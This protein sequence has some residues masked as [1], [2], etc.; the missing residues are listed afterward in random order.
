MQAIMESLFDVL[1]LSTVT[2]LGVQ[3]IVGSKRNKFFRVFG[4]MAIILGFGDAFHLIPRMIALWGE[5]VEA[6]AFSLGLGK[7]ITSFTMTIFYVILYHIWE[8]YYNVR[9]TKTLTIS[10]YVLAFIRI[11]LL[12]FPQND[13]FSINSPL[14]WG[15]YR[16]IPFALLGIL[17]IILFY[18]EAKEMHDQVFKYMWLA[19]TL[20]F[21][22]YIPVVLWADVYPLVGMLMIPKTCAYVWMVWMGYSEFKK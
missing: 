3:M 19:I 9:S 15:I 18:R 8:M 7:L 11:A 2:Y 12:F 4:V 20:S 13:W 10:V 22:F 5:G 6:H 21:A 16:N 14:S 17:I 1:Y